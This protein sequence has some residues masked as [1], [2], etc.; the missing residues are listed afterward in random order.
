MHPSRD[1][2]LPPDPDAYRH[3]APSHADASSSS[4][5]PAPPARRSSWR[6]GLQ[7][8][9]L[10]E[11]E[12]GAEIRELAAVRQG[13]RHRGRHRHR[14][15]RSASAPS[16]R[17]SCASRSGTAWSTAS[18]RPRRRRRLE[19]RHRHHRHRAA[20]VPG[21]P[22]HRA[23]HPHRGRDPPDLRRA[24]AVPRAGQAGR[25]P[26]HLAQRHGGSRL[27]RPVPR[28]APT[29]SRPAPSIPQLRAKVEV[30]PQTPE[31]FLDDRYIR[32]VIK[33]R[34][35]VAVFVPTRAEVERLAAELGEQW[36]RAHDGVLSRRRADPGDPA[37]S[38]GRGGA[39][40]PAGDDGGGPVGAQRPRARH[41]GHLRRALRQRGRARP[42]RAAP[43]LPRRQ[44]DPAD[45]RPGARP[46]AGRRGRR[47]SATASSTSR[48]CG[49]RRR[50]SSSPATPSGWR[51]P[52]PR[53]AWTP[54]TSTCRCRSTGRPTGGRSSCS[55][56]AGWSRTAGSP[57]TAARSRRCRSSGPGASCW[58]T[59]TRELLPIVAVCS[60]IESLHRMT[61]E[62]R[63]LHGVV[64]NG[65]DHLTAYNL[66]AEAVNQHGYLGRGVRA[67][68]PSVRGRARGV[69]RAPRRAGQGDRGHRA[70]HGVGVPRRSSCRCPKQLPYASKELR[71]AVGRAD[72]AGH[73]VRPGHRRA[74]RRRPGGAG[75]QDV[76][77]GKLGRGGRD[78]PLLRR[79]VRRAAGVDRG[80][81]D[82]RTTW[83]ARTRGSGPPEVVLT[84]RPQAP[85]PG[86]RAAADLLRLRAGDRGRAAGGA[87][88]RGAAPGRE[89]CAG[90][91]AAGG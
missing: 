10:L 16:P 86:G 17:R 81:D 36:P 34:R 47:S 39:A 57:P 22:D 71:Q 33:E 8:E 1:H 77:G 29:C 3:A 53:S 15:R 4:P 60:N 58:S 83:S 80:H 45:G 46:G 72:R 31:E 49:P 24:R 43:A 76:G 90:G 89:G 20:L 59:P 25:L 79:P 84:G 54:A 74:H 87:D 12:H 13:L 64:V 30:L 56:S 78:P 61:R 40:V 44:R 21:R 7:L 91:R 70:R 18:A 2:H 66:Y 38:R 11:R 23:R 48:S 52:A 67:A 14:E 82:L 26:V 41:R 28:T 42:Q 65:S 37:V 9:T 5:P 27:L 63:D 62:E 68:A 55:P 69:G 19:R 75:L 50:S 6:S 32:H 88:P 85:A 73:A 35:G 51:S